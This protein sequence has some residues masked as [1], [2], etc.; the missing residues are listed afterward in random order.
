MLTTGIIFYI[1]SGF[2]LLVLVWLLRLEIKFKRLLPGK[3]H[4]LE[5]SL[6]SIQDAVKELKKF[7]IDSVA[8]LGTV[9]ERLQ[10]SVQGVET[11]R[12]NPFQGRGEGGKQ[13]F[14]TALINEK[15]DG[16][17]IS[18]LYSRERV[19]MFA[20]PLKCFVSEFELSDEEKE[21]LQKARKSFSNHKDKNGK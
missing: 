3:S 16:V 17:V 10:C 9:E 13:S 5:E 11:I 4:N 19:S 12:F 8:Y 18:S 14:A 6:T 7:Q 2:A 1:V 15:G 20:K 21:A